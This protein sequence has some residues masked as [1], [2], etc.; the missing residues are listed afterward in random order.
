M[1]KRGDPAALA[2]LGIDHTA[3]P[4]RRVVGAL[5]GSDQV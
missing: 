4:A 3:G 2:M 5:Q 1:V